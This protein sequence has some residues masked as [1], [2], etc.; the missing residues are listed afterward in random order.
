MSEEKRPFQ[1]IQYQD[2]FKV[3]Q[4]LLYAYD[5]T[6]EYEEELSREYLLEDMVSLLYVSKDITI[7]VGWY[8]NH[9]RNSGVFK[10]H[11]IQSI[12]WENPLM[13]L[14]AKS[15]TEITEMLNTVMEH[16]ATEQFP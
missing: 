1:K 8:G 3:M 4:Y 15:L 6:T 5:P 13:V 12:D 2:G 9:A 16:I 10:I 14:E 7:D 11:I